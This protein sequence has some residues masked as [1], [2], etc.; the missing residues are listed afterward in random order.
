[1]T[2]KV[3]RGVFETNSSSTHAISIAEA[4][5]FTDTLHP[6]DDGVVQIEVGEYGWEWETYSDAWS[7]ASY[8]AT[9]LATMAIEKGPTKGDPIAYSNRSQYKFF[10]GGYVMF[11][12]FCT[13]I[14]EHTGATDVWIMP[15]HGND[16]YWP[17]GYIDHQ[18]D[19]VYRNAVHSKEACKS[20]LFCRKSVLYTGNDNSE[21]DAMMDLIHDINEKSKFNRDRSWDEWKKKNTD[22]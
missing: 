16:N 2:T 6:N 21:N 11:E 12:N 3:R 4:P 1:M 22:S 15:Q 20:A 19:G 9:G 10:P 7:K 17:F 5:T 14:M 8:L 13:T 18:S